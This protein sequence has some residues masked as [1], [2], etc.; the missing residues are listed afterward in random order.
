M[1]VFAPMMGATALTAVRVIASPERS[2]GQLSRVLVAG[3]IATAALAT[4]ET[5]RP[6]EAAGL[7]TVV[8]LT[9]F[10]IHGVALAQLAQRAANISVPPPTP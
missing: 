1:T 3:T 4:V 6:R 10:L 7:A 9:A 8:F 2:A 5:V